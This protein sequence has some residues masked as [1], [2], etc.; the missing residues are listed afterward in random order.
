MQAAF[1]VVSRCAAAVTVVICLTAIVLAV[2]KDKAIDI[3]GAVTG[4]FP[5]RLLPAPGQ[6][7][8]QTN[9]MPTPVSA[10]V[11]GMQFSTIGSGG[12]SILTTQYA[13][14]QF[15]LTEITMITEI[16]A[17]MNHFG[18]GTQPFRVMIVRSTNGVPDPSGVFRTFLLS[19]DGDLAKIS[20]ESAAMNLVLRPGTYFALFAPQG[21]DE[22]FILASSGSFLA[23]LLNLGSVDPTGALPAQASLQYAA[24][25]VRGKEIT[26]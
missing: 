10:L 3:G 12:F 21:N 17:F 11:D 2:D 8:M 16:G 18:P 22:G 14:P 4:V 1:L 13:G 20:Y 15:T 6:A 23:G 5:Q 24:V 9:Q 25:T 19:S 7:F 26:N